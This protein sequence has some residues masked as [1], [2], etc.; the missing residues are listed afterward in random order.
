MTAWRGALLASLGLAATGGCG[1][2][3]PEC[4]DSEGDPTGM[5]RCSEGWLHRPEPVQC[6]SELPRDVEFPASNGLLDQCTRDSDC[7]RFKL[8]FC[9]KL[10]GLETHTVCI[11]GCTQD[12][13]CEP[14]MACVCGSPAGVC[15]PATC[16]TDQDCRGAYCSAIESLGCDERPHWVIGCATPEDECESHAQCDSG[17]LCGRADSG[18]TT[19]YRPTVICGRPFLVEDRARLAEATFSAAWS[20]SSTPQIANLPAFT[21]SSLAE[22]WSALGLMEHASIAAFSRFILDLLSLGA[23]AALVESASC[24]LSDEIAHAELCFGLASACAGYPVGPGPIS[25][26]GALTP[27]SRLELGVLAFREACIGEVQAAAEARLALEHARDPVVQGVLQRVAADETRHAE[28]GFRFLKWLLETAT[29]EQRDELTA[30]LE[31]E[32]LTAER[33]LCCDSAPEAPE[34]GL[35]PA[36]ERARARRE[37]FQEV[38]RPCATA[39]LHQS[40]RRASPASRRSADTLAGTVV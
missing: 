6:K 8:G 23:P 31:R 17:E 20:V 21:R 39:L 38:T 34:H 29:T 3:G 4:T 18:Q 30:A 7:A 13:D 37:A 19:C 11:E 27:S 16:R 26:Q 15:Q 1:E 28:L 5:W 40:I 24:A 25:L 22:H 14:G 35:P 12:S 2:T 36:R 33:F 32:L 9:V 10:G